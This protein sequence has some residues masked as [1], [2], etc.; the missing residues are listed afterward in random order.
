MPKFRHEEDEP[1]F[2]DGVLERIFSRPETRSI[3]VGTQSTMIHA[4]EEAL[5]EILEENPYVSLSELLG[6]ATDN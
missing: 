4:I 2:A 1:M 6:T 5:Q 3:P